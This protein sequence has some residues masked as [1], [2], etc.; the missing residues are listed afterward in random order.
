MRGEWA[1]DGLSEAIP[2]I[3]SEAVDGFRFAQPIL[4]ASS[5]VIVP[6][7]RGDDINAAAPANEDAYRVGFDG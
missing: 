7:M 2:I 4:Q 6:R 3:L 1:Q 5:S